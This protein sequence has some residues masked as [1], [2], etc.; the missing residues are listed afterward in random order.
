MTQHHDA[1]SQYRSGKSG[2]IG[3]LVGQVMKATRGKANPKL[4]NEL[5]RKAIEG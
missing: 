3:F 5:L 2:A 1:V 4:V